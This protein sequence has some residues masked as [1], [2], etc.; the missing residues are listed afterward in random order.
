MQPFNRCIDTFLVTAGFLAGADS[1]AEAAVLA[2]PRPVY[3]L[4]AATAQAAVTDIPAG[5]AV[6]VIDP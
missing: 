3:A 2:V 1:A 4:P 6:V 5:T